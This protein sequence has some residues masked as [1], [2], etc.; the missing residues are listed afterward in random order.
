MKMLSLLACA[1]AVTLFGCHTTSTAPT[2]MLTGHFIS[3]APH[4]INIAVDAPGNLNQQLILPMSD[5]VKVVSGGH[6]TSFEKVPYN[7][8]IKVTRNLNTR[9][10]T[11]VELS[12]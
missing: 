4:M 5:H 9:Q 6:E 2:Q 3:T 8:P 12:Q 7:S 10:V 1:F 11:R